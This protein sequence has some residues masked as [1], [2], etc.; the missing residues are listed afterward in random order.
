LVLCFDIRSALK[1]VLGELMPLI[2]FPCMEM[3]ELATIVA[4]R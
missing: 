3:Q 1:E 4:P 2:R